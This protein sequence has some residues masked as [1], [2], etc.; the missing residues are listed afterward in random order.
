MLKIICGNDFC[1]NLIYC[2]LYE[3]SFKMF[4]IYEYYNI[5]FDSDR[6]FCLVL[7]N[8]EDNEVSWRV[9]DIFS[10]VNKVR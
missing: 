5:V 7:E 4:D 1:I 3:G 6:N 9:C 2:V 10:L 8:K